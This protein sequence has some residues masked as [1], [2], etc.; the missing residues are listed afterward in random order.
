MR[1][2]TGASREP[3]PSTTLGAPRERGCPLQQQKHDRSCRTSS[4]LQHHSPGGGPGDCD[5]QL[6]CR[7]AQVDSWLG[8]LGTRHDDDE[9]FRRGERMGRVGFDSR[10]L[11]PWMAGHPCLTLRARSL[12]LQ[13]DPANIGKG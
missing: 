11:S 4:T 3:P 5:L 13:G 8:Q 9:A 7:L 2:M 1:W 12:S 10:T 6:H